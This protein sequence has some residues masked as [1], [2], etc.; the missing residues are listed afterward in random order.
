VLQKRVV[1]R[2]RGGEDAS[3][4]TIEVLDQ[5][6]TQAEPLGDDERPFVVTMNTDQEINKDSLN[7][8]VTKR[9]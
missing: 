7:K 9:C 4:A 5:Q 1:E 3:E 6:I 8:L 2:E